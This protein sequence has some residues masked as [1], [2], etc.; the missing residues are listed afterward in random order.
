LETSL[1]GYHALALVVTM[2]LKSKKRKYTKKRTEKITKQTKWPY[3]MEIGLYN[4]P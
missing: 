1:S 2:K 4:T 3:V